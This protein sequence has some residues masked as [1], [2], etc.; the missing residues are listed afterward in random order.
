MRVSLILLILSVT[1]F[2]SC[3][4]GNSENP[5]SNPHTFNLSDLPVPC[6]D[7]SANHAL[8]G[9]W[10]AQ[11]DLENLSVSLIRERS[12]LTHFNVRDLIPPPE[13][14]VI[15]YNGISHVINVD[16]TIRNPSALDVYDVRLIIFTDNTGHLLLD[17][18]EWTPL[19]DIS[20]GLS[21]NPFR[22]FNKSVTERKFPGLSQ[23]TQSLSIYLPNGNTGV[24]FAVDASFPSNCE[25]PYEIRDFS[26]GTLYD[27]AGYS[28][29]IS[30]TV[31]DHQDDVNSVKLYCPEITGEIFVS[32][33]SSGNDVWGMQ[34]VN[35]SGARAAEYSG[36]IIAT[37]SN[38][39]SLALID[40]VTI[41]IDCYQYPGWVL[42]WATSLTTGYDVV[43]DSGGNIYTAGSY[44]PNAV[45][46]VLFKIHYQG[47][48]V[49]GYKWGGE[50]K[51]HVLGLA[52][53][54]SDNVYIC[55]GF[56]NQ[57]D[58]DPGPGEAIR[59]AENTSDAFL[60]SFDSDGNFRWVNTW[61][62]FE[63]QQVG[64]D[65]SDAVYV[66]GAFDGE[67]D[68]NPGT[69]VDMHTS[70]GL[71]DAFLTSYDTDGNYRWT[72]TWGGSE[73]DC[74]FGVCASNNQHIYAAGGFKNTV[75]FDPS[76]QLWRTNSNGQADAFISRFDNSGNFYWSNAWGSGN[77]DCALDVSSDYY[78]MVYVTGYFWYEID[79]NPGTGT[80][81][82]TSQGLEDAF[83][84]KF[85]VD[86]NYQWALTWGGPGKDK[87]YSLCNFAT[88]YVYVT[89][90][91]RNNVDLNP[92]SGV[93]NHV[94]HGDIDIFLSKIGSNGTYVWGRSWG[95]EREDW[96]TS[97]AT[98]SVGDIYLNGLFQDTVDFDPGDDVYNVKMKAQT[99]D[100]FLMRLLPNG[101]WE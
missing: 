62:A 16:V 4:A 68:F 67:R 50:G 75:D 35:N 14:N 23:S 64:F 100:A 96:G 52:I 18:D 61:P 84:S 76:P 34:L 53:D 24:M 92:G 66:G 26:Q 101:Y 89:G 27:R 7:E 71:Y 1:V 55:G 86:G 93:D 20:G 78:N 21:S 49:W 91:F 6:S 99:R 8:F 3:S 70:S 37:S 10:I 63:G 90:G 43:V 60:C 17:P 38:S 65:G 94:S 25:E 22:A 57:V 74:I 2:C 58:F 54:N 59:T 69:E 36:F 12:A 48:Y 41:R 19:Y 30:I 81:M 56:G 80:D 88:S 5:I 82:H 73:D 98:N 46:L 39:G 95:A 32:L 72:K 33:T 13:I 31:H 44:A 15:S 42:N 9:V 11:F 87:G 85:N 47:Y 97:V 83:L 79:F 77:D 40:Q 51:D 29:D 45:D 28:T